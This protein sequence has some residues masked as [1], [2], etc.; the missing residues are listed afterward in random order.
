MDGMS[1]RYVGDLEQIKRDIEAVKQQAKKK[2]A[3]K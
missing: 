3:A 2:P 1:G